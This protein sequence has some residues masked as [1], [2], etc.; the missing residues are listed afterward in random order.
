MERSPA[1]RCITNSRAGHC[2]RKKSS[3]WVH[4][5]RRPGSGACAGIIHH[6]LKP[7]NLHI[8]K[9]DRLKILDFGL[10][11]WI[12]TATGQLGVTVSKAHEITGTLPTWLRSNCA[13]SGR[14]AHRLYSAGAVLYERPPASGR[15]FK[16]RGH[17]SSQPFWNA[18]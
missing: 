9:D 5:W 1:S 6:D 3:A 10:A 11:Q 4:S 7:G 16:P 18:H 2:P 14:P 8:T 17:N 12:P 15:I 13:A